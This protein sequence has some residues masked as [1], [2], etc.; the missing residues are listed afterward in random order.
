MASSFLI[1]NA[2][3]N[4][5]VLNRVKILKLLD[6]Q[7]ENNENN[8]NNEKLYFYVLRITNINISNNKI[9][10]DKQNIKDIYMLTDEDLKSQVNRVYL[11]NSEIDYITKIPILI[12]DKGLNIESVK[13]SKLIVESNK[14]SYDID[15]SII[16][17]INEEV[18]L[19]FALNTDFSNEVN[20]Y[21]T[22]SIPNTLQ[23]KCECI[24]NDFDVSPIDE[25]GE[26]I[27]W[28][29][30]L[31]LPK[32]YNKEYTFNCECSGDTKLKT[33]KGLSYLYA[34][35]KN[36]T[37]VLKNKPINDKTGPLFRTLNQCSEQSIIWN[38][39]GSKTSIPGK[40]QDSFIDGHTKGA[41]YF[42]KESGFIMNS[43]FPNFP[44]PDNFIVGCQEDDNIIFSQHIFAFSVNKE[45]M[46]KWSEAMA[47]VKVNVLIQKNWQFS[48][49]T[50]G[51]KSVVVNL[52]TNDGKKITCVIKGNQDY[53][54]PYYYVA[55]R[56]ETS[57]KVVSWRVDNKLRDITTGKKYDKYE[58]LTGV[59]D[60]EGDVIAKYDIT[61]INK[62][63]Y[64]KISWDA[65]GYN[66]KKFILKDA[67]D[68]NHAKFA[69]GVNKQCI[70]LGS[71]NMTHEQ[72]SRSG[73]FYAIDDST[74]YKE[75]HNLINKS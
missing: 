28:F 29:F 6:L 23:N 9:S 57:L 32:S 64:D 66:R 54:R 38:D 51:G 72:N 15:N 14:V 19:T 39:Q 71:L 55:T 35:S 47:N 74:F 59:P 46:Q 17:K 48:P 70:V 45:N 41:A 62:L 26:Q 73:D 4:R 40:Y 63:S 21:Y 60:S 10:F 61:A 5:T 36:P 16:N 67:E 31:K 42:G 75:I 1:N 49:L 34:D 56:L 20:Y 25:N 11:N 37:L 43:S 3:L 27:D 8:E 33:S 58:Y 18:I 44:D 30:I 50:T 22:T 12:I 24:N 13:S 53:Y 69:I 7:N 2:F 52:E 65:N 68:K